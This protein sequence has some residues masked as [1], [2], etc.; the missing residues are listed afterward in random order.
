MMSAYGGDFFAQWQV[1]D[2]LCDERVCP[3]SQLVY[4]H[5][6]QDTCMESVTMNAL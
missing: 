4:V 3:C 5:V 2:V 1:V 6:T